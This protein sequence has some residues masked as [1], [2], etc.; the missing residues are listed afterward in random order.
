M[1][2]VLSFLLLF[3]C[4]TVL[5]QQPPKD[6]KAVDIKNIKLDP[7]KLKVEAAKNACACIEKIET[8]DQNKEGNAAAIQK[9]I[10]EQAMV[11]QM[12]AAIVG[13]LQTGNTKIAVSADK[14][15]D[16]YQ[17]AYRE[18]ERYLMDSCEATKKKAAT[19]DKTGY[20]SLSSDEKAM[21]KYREG[22]ALV[23]KQDYQG[24]IACYQKALKIDSQFA[25]AWDNLGLCYRKT[26]AY[27]KA[28]AAYEESIKI[29]ST[30]KTPIQNLAVVYIY[31]K[32]YNKAAEA[33]QRLAAIDANEPEVF[34]GLGQLYALYLKDNQKGLDY[35]CKAYNLYVKTGSPYRTDAEK[36]IGMI[37]GEMKKEGKEKEFDAILKANNIVQE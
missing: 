17:T 12:T 31:Q 30:N 19:T 18:L 4:F 13:S 15:S 1:K 35:M 28:I 26:E 9:C 29:D 33:Y 5:A 16:S 32:N 22:N 25:F 11:Y 20:H 10:E 3:A 8:A 37:Y 36:V 6:A 21:E 27:E 23:E 14:T 2:N 7:N 34:Y 24:A